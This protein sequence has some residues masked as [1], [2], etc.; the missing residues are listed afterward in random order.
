MSVT[1]GGL[2]ATLVEAALDLL[3][4]GVGDVS[5]RAVARAAGVSAMA[6][7]RHF[8]DKAA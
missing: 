8:P 7:Y 4:H 3:E 6:P 2:R 1:D 5:L